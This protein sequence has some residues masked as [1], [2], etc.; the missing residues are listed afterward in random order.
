MLF[1]HHRGISSIGR[2]RALQAWG[3]GIEAR[4]LHLW[5]YSVMVITLDF[6]SSNPGSNPGRTFFLYF[7][8]TKLQKKSLPS[9]EIESGT[10]RSSV[11]RSPNWA[12]TAVRHPGVEPGPPR[13]QRGIIAARLMAHLIG[14]I[15]TIDLG[16]TAETIYSPPLYQLSY[17]EVGWWRMVSSDVLIGCVVFFVEKKKHTTPTIPVWSPTTVLGRPILAWLRSSDG[18]RYIQEG[19]IVWYLKT[20]FFH[21]SC[22]SCKKN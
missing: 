9:P 17:D 10:F 2:V 1:S 21:T 20:F 14:R 19:M 8:W 22:T 16:I 18:I 5:S 15:R 7:C 6:E 13:W 12:T 4:I 3:T 11:W